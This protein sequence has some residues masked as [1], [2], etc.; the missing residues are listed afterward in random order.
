MAEPEI[1]R[2]GKEFHRRVQEDWKKTARGGHISPE[3]TISL[4]P[5]D[6]QHKK[7]GRLDIF[8]DETGDFVSVKV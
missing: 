7:H 4:V 5:Q 2:K 8:A 6:A 1:L 3:H